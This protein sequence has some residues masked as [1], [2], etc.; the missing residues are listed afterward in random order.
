MHEN[1]LKKVEKVQ[2]ITQ[3][4]YEKGRLDKCYA[5]IWRHYIYP[6][7]P[8]CYESYRSMLKIDVAKERKQMKRA[9][10]FRNSSNS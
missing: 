6:L 7:F 3:E 5:Q 4:H 10:Y 9:A 2:K 1:Y 8:M